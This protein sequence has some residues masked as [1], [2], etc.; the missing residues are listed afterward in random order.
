MTGE[1]TRGTQTALF[2]R[3]QAGGD[4]EIRYQKPDRQEQQVKPAGLDMVVV[5]EA[6]LKFAQPRPRQWRRMKSEAVHAVF[7]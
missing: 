4:G 5:M 6:M 3:E 7:A 2:G 1:G